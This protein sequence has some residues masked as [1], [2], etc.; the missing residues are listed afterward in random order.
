MHDLNP[1]VDI[2]NA[3]AKL[4]YESITHQFSRCWSVQVLDM[5]KWNQAELVLNCPR[6]DIRNGLSLSV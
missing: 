3:I 2:F 4:A 6:F 1:K 5:E